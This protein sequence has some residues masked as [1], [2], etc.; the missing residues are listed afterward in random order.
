M[1]LTWSVIF[2]IACA[3]MLLPWWA[4]FRRDVAERKRVV[5]WVALLCTSV[6]ALAGPWALLHAAELSRRSGLDYRYEGKAWVV[7]AVGFI[8]SIAW[9]KR[10]RQWRSLLTFCVAGVLILIWTMSMLTI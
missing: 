6:A 7:A 5:A 4:F 8:S 1:M 10:S 2:G 9:V 3:L